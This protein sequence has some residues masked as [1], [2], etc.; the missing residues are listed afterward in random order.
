MVGFLND[1]IYFLKLLLKPGLLHRQIE[2]MIGLF[3]VRFVDQEVFLL[4]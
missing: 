4:A 1:F 3:S 2:A